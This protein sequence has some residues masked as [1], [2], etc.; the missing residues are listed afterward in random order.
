MNQQITKEVEKI[1]RTTKH[2]ASWIARKWD[3]KVTPN[4]INNTA[5]RCPNDKNINQHKVLNSCLISESNFRKLHYSYKERDMW[6]KIWKIQVY[7]INY[8]ILGKVNVR[9]CSES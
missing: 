3:E 1:L 7:N 4:K 2:G 8:L 6:M 9:S 5:D